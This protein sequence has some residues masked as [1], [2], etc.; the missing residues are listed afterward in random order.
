MN[1]KLCRPDDT[2]DYK[3]N[4][5]LAID[6]QPHTN[7]TQCIRCGWCTDHCPARLNVSALNDTFEMSQINH[8]KKL[9][10]IACVDCGICSYVC[11]ARLPLH[12][13]IRRLY[14]A[15]KSINSAMPL[16]N[17]TQRSGKDE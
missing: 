3:T 1:G 4:A 13:R 7:A 9:G 8:A 15:V 6:P 16:F 14:K 5:L 2:V 10:V 17:T 12:K 11:P